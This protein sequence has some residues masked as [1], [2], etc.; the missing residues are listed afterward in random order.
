MK[1]F[2]YVFI[3][4]LVLGLTVPAASSQMPDIPDTGELFGDL[5]VILRDEDGVPILAD[6]TITDGEGNVIEGACVQP[7]S[8]T[9]GIVT[10]ETNG[11][12][13]EIEV[14]EG[15][16]FAL[17]TY[18]DALG[19]VVEC[20]LTEEMLAWVQS[21]DFGRLN[22]GRAPDSV[23]AHAFDE[24]INKLNNARG[25]AIDPA[26]RLVLTLPDPENEDLDVVKTVD[27]PA[28]NLAL[29]I[30][31]MTEGH[32]ITPEDTVIVKDKRPD[33]VGP[34]VGD[35]PSTEPRPV[36]DCWEDEEHSIPSALQGRLAELGYGGLCDDD[37]T[38]GEQ[39][40]RD[41]LLLA[42][43]LL[44]AAADKTG[45]ITLDKVM[46]I[47]SIYGINQLGSIVP[48][49]GKNFFNFGIALGD[50][51]SYV[52]ATH[53]QSRSSGTCNPGYIWVLQPELDE[54]DAQVPGH[55]VTTCMDILGHEAGADP[56]EEN[57]VHFVDGVEA[58]TTVFDE[59]GAPLAYTFDVN[60]RGFVQAA[61][62]ALQVL[63]YIHNYKT[64]ED[65]YGVYTPEE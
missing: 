54:G 30:K 6:Y 13:L 8:A 10:I 55:Y 1:A 16:P 42:A 26:G 36:L 56:Y 3:L 61:D 50:P 21:V 5:Y 17:P 44:A 4:I 45:S 51:D 29:Y 23:I 43:S 46:Y 53:F 7:I 11:E 9:D 33:D 31:M 20:E 28:E 22:L 48:D 58:Y 15:E 59:Y 60:V 41:E 12:P 25:I 57:A 38:T 37:R 47:N 24:A 14:F 63:E 49:E 40:T 2:K 65:L 32:W 18:T 39:L 64:P 19:D 34:P 27:S 62:D 35:G 52:R